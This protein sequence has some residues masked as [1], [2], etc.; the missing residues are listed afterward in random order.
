MF[1]V[2]FSRFWRFSYFLRSGYGICAQFTYTLYSLIYCICDICS[3][4][5][6]KQPTAIQSLVLLFIIILCA[7]IKT[8][9]ENLRITSFL[10]LSLISFSYVIWNHGVYLLISF[11]GLRVLKSKMSLFW[12]SVICFAT[13]SSSMA[14]FIGGEQDVGS[15]L[16]VAQCRATCLERVSRSHIYP[17]FSLCVWCKR[18]W[19]PAFDNNPYILC[20][21][22]NIKHKFG[23]WNNVFIFRSHLIGTCMKNCFL[24][25]FRIEIIHCFL[26]QYCINLISIT[27]FFFLR[28]KI[29]NAE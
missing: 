24:W 23:K 27:I 9:C 26:F 19:L 7:F 10:F 18:K 16:R 8:L 11:F 6:W 29:D 5:R 2:S 13:M 21:I 15:P 17:W 20:N 3:D 4:P 28:E 14:I 1:L 22:N 12:R 25:K